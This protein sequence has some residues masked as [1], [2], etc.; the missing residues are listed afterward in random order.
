MN[1]VIELGKV[2]EKTKGVA[3]AIEHPGV[4]FKGPR[5]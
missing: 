2:S 3:G 4:P 1:K 5:G